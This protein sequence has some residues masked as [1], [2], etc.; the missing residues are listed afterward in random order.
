MRAVIFSRAVT[1]TPPF[2]RLCLCVLGI[3]AVSLTGCTN[4]LNRAIYREKP[5][6]IDR[7]LASGADINTADGNGGTPLIYAAQAN[8][9]PLM[10]KLLE[11]GAHV[12]AMDRKGNSA[13]SYAVAREAFDPEAVALLLKFHAS[14]NVVNHEGHAPLHLA[15]LRTCAATDGPRQVELFKLLVTAGADPNAMPTQELPL[16]E[17]AQNG[18]PEMALDYLLGV[19]KT[20]QAINRDGYT[21][22]STAALYDHPDAVKFFV[23]HGF[24]PQLFVITPPPP[25]QELTANPIHVINARTKDGFGDYLLAKNEAAKALA[26]YH[27]SAAEYVVAIREAQ[28]SIEDCTAQLKEAK[29]KRRNKWIS[30]VALSAVGAGLGAAT[31][32]GFVAVPRRTENPIDDLEA[33]IEH[34][35]SEVASLTR[36]QIALATKIQDAE[37]RVKA[38]PVPPPAGRVSAA[39]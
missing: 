5:E 12:D 6:A 3:L 4:T 16:H 29:S 7:Y 18:Q 25:G 8:N 10:K 15:A 28:R 30:A 22:L 26:S 1:F 33:Q 14:V 32:V 38:A 11:R 13:L 35:Q 34:D 20:P 37:A 31:G 2:H 39:P 21:A 23:N 17:A 36:Q 19:T 9:L 24:E 27:E